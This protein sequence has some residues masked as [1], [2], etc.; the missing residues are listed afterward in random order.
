MRVFQVRQGVEADPGIYVDP[1]GITLGQEGPGRVRTIVPMIPPPVKPVLFERLSVEMTKAGPVLVPAPKKDHDPRILVAFVG[2]PGDGP[3]ANY[4]VPLPE[5]SIVV[6]RGRGAHG[7]DGRRGWWEEVLAILPV[8]GEIRLRN[9][10]GSRVLRWGFRHVVR[11][12]TPEEE[13]SED[14]EAVPECLIRML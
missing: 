12:L 2:D 9:K 7:K 3:G 14:A 13:A 1:E 5:G 10:R 11:L 4:P 6:A 8:C